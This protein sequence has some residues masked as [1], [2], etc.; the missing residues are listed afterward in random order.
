M[1]EAASAPVMNKK[2]KTDKMT[3]FAAL[4]TS[5]QVKTIHEASLEILENVGLLVRSGKARTCF[6]QHGC[7][8]DSETQIVK[9]PPGLVEHWC[10][11]FPST[12]TFHGRDPQYDRTIPD[13]GPLIA[14]SSSA[15]NIIDPDT[16]QE[17]RSR[18]DDIARIAHLVN[19][20]P[21]Y[22]VFS[23]SITADD[24][25]PG[26]FYLS[27]FYPTLKNCLKPVQ[28]SAPNAQEAEAILRLGCLIAGSE[29]AYRAR[30]FITYICCPI[31]SPLTMDADSTEIT[32]H[33]IE[34]QLPNYACIVPNAGLTAPLT[35]LGTLTQCNAEFLAYAMLV[36]MTRPGT[37]LIY[38]VLP[39]VADVR[40]AAYATGGIETGILVMG[41]AQMA[42]Y[43]DVPCSAMAGLPN[44]KVNDAQ[45]GFETGMSALAAV[46]AGVD[47]V[48]MGGLLDALM[49]F[50]FAKLVID[51]E[52]ALMLKRV[53]RGVEPFSEENLALDVIAEVGPGG[54]FI[55]TR[56]T[57]KR[58]WTTA[59]LPEIADRSSRQQW[60]AEGAL[61]AHDRAMQRVREILAGDNPAIFS[62][63]VDAR[64]RARFEGLVAGDAAEGWS[65]G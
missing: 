18:S 57:L 10:T 45:S 47:L 24:A 43:Y 7:H 21:G 64:I 12:F 53:I 40:T 33:F 8:V 54:M 25:P 32:M 28:G 41:C 39:T 11:A 52:I 42:R 55:D 34:E 60:E 4:L 63:D 16:G 29:E 27:R 17:R 50:D 36:Q 2:G 62:P 51:N 19:E 46:L 37:P 61:E 14:T 30:P 48:S 22:D 65:D 9:F 13:D 1:Y 3:T 6:A 15:P 35:L 44:A 59:L 31:I 5:E 58:M 49:A 20:L 56:H 26:Q 38:G 23:I